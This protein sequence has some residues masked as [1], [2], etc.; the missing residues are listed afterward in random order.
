MSLPGSASLSAAPETSVS[1]RLV[2]GDKGGDGEKQ[3][4]SHLLLVALCALPWWMCE[5]ANF[6]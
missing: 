5:A 4:V 2:N 3:G 1:L 6:S